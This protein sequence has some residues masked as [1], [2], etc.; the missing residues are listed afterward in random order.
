MTLA[1]V[2]CLSIR[3]KIY[4]IPR[5]N[6]DTQI[7]IQE[8]FRSTFEFDGIEE[9][10]KSS[11]FS[12]PF[13]DSKVRLRRNEFPIFYKRYYDAQEI[14][15]DRNVAISRHEEMI[16]QLCLVEGCAYDD[17]FLT[18][19][20]QYGSAREALYAESIRIKLEEFQNAST[21]LRHTS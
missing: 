8:I 2:R 21:L 3:T 17:E 14:E 16:H 19:F 7:C 20:R 15:A 4:V 5:N 11:S 9:N 6:T 1:D 13:P 18:K 12:I 10:V